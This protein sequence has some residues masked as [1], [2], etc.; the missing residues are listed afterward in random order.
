M[1][2]VIQYAERQQEWDLPLLLPLRCP[3]AAMPFEYILH[4]L[5]LQT[6]HRD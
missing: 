3:R 2:N 1:K 6:D 5:E 4:W